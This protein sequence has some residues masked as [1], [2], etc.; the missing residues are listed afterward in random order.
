MPAE[1]KKISELAS[2]SAPAWG[3]SLAGV[4]ISE[5]AAADKNKRL[6]LDVL[7]RFMGGRPFNFAI[8]SGSKEAVEVSF[9]E[10][11]SP[12]PDRAGILCSY[13]TNAD[14]AVVE[15]EIVPGSLTATTC[16]VRAKSDNHTGIAGTLVVR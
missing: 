14:A 10:T 9:G 11:L 6:L 5:A 3:D 8:S 4:D 16:E 12:T 13:Q 15:V 1:S 2:L 7:A